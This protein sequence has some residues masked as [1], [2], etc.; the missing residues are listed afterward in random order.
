MQ[1]HS[2]LWLGWEIFSSLIIFQMSNAPSAN[3]VLLLP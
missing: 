1:P 3:V 2:G